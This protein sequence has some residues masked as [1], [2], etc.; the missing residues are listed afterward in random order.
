MENVEN[1]VNETV[2]TNT[3]VETDSTENTI[4]DTAAG[5]TYKGSQG[6][7]AAQK[8][9][10]KKIIIGAAA[11][12]LALVIVAIIAVFVFLQK[13]DK[14]VVGTAFIN[15]AEEM[16]A[17][18]DPIE[19]AIGA[20]DM[21]KAYYE[22][23]TTMDYSMNLTMPTEVDFP[24]IGLDGTFAK[25]VPDKKIQS[26]T[27]VS[28]AN[29]DLLNADVYADDAKMYLG[30]PELLGQDTYVN[31]NM[32]TFGEDFNNSFLASYAGIQEDASLSIDPYAA[33]PEAVDYSMDDF[34][35]AYAEDVK[36]LITN[37]QVENADTKYTLAK[38]DSEVECDLYTV[39]IPQA[40]AN[41]MIK[42]FAETDAMQSVEEELEKNRASMAAMGEEEAFNAVMDSWND[43]LTNGI[44][45]D[46]L[47][48]VAVS[49]KKVVMIQT[50]EDIAIS[51][52]EITP[53][54]GFATT[55]TGDT[56]VS[57]VQDYTVDVTINDETMTMALNS[58]W[59][60]ADLSYGCT[61]SMSLADETYAF[62]L[63]GTF[64]DVT[65]GSAFVMNIDQLDVTYN[66]EQ[67]MAI[68]GN[69]GMKELSEDIVI[70]QGTQYDLFNLTE[71]D[72]M[73][74]ANVVME[75]VYTWQNTLSMIQ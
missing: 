27:T 73:G 3:T 59:S 61:G 69:F 33:M 43:F 51:M 38:A 44:Q 34:K 35:T 29:V 39:T 24:T 21:M 71:T 6:P 46:M 2:E 41:Q 20:E 1:N 65:K 11:A 53:A 7:D 37:I 15:L 66:D 63:N 48:E 18:N 62:H 67:M 4:V 5:E 55:F 14:A 64:A 17:E 25:N 19:A 30:I 54:I 57:D 42:D 10:N 28:M 40:D 68:T 32:A 74:L 12:I 47:L 75:N 72:L 50:T 45:G 56:R 31:F 36:N 26:T 58:T 22:G 70:P 52:G 49:D 8:K 60:D 16:S 23:K 9:S 13:D